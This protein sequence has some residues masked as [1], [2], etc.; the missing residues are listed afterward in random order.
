MP[1]RTVVC[2]EVAGL[3]A[4]RATDA[5]ATDQAFRLVEQLLRS[6]MLNTRGSEIHGYGNAFVGQ[7]PDAHGAMTW[8]IEVQRDL[9][10]IDWPASC[11][12]YTSDA[13]DE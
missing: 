3:E 8:A 1:Y 6:A 10:A 4:A 13:A 2:A 7:W 5:G 9:L 11:L 12:L